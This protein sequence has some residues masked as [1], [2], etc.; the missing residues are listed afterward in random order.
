[1][2]VQDTKVGYVFTLEYFTPSWPVIVTE[3]ITNRCHEPIGVFSSVPS[4]LHYR[5]VQL[6]PLGLQQQVALH[7]GYT[8]W[9]LL[10]IKHSY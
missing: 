1:M 8:L 10:K 3:S 2:T 6:K 5:N 4:N 7:T 9:T